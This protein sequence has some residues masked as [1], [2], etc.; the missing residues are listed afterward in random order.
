MSTLRITTDDG[1]TWF[2]P[3]SMVNGDASWHLDPEARTI[4]I[5]LFWYT[6]GKG[7]QDVEVADTQRVEDPGVSGHRRFRL[8]LPDR[9]YSFSGTLITLNWALELVALPGNDTA[10]VNLLV[11]P[12]PVEV[13]IR[14]LR[15]L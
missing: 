15:E 5:R 3:G 11:G 9:P 8:R 7:T 1:Q 14:G 13:S 6:E 10:R 12:R 4:E 2:S